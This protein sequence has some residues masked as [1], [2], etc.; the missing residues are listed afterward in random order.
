MSAALRIAVV[1]CGI[2]GLSA[3]L[4]LHRQ[5]HEL[6]LF[7]QFAQPEPVGSGL[8][9]QPTG[10][11]VLAR[12][13]LAHK[14]WARGAEIDGLWGLTRDGKRALDAS[15]ADLGRANCFGIGIHRSS[16]FGI[17]YDAVC[18]E[19]IPMQ[20]GASIASAHPAY[21]RC[22]LY[23]PDN[24]NLGDFDLVV[25]AAGLHSPLVPH[26]FA[27]LP[28][29]A[30]WANVEW[31]DGLGFN[32][33]LLE[34]RYLEARQ[35]VGL[36]PVGRR[37][38]E[39][40]AEAAFFWSITEHDFQSWQKAPLSEWKDQVLALWPQLGPVV[41][42]IHNH[43]QLTYA[44]YAH[45]TLRHPLDRRLIHIGDA[46]HSA[47][48]QLGQGANMALLD[49]W[50]VAR[51]FELASSTDDALRMAVSLRS[52]HVHLYQYVTA[53]FTPLF[54]SQDSLPA[55]IRDRMT[56]PLSKYWPAK[57]I[58]SQLLSGLFGAPL[59]QLGLDVPDYQELANAARIAS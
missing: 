30:L 50:A 20:T 22:R 47:S 18:A 53:F 59:Q 44:R 41:D 55:L 49:A 42:Q 21:D 7:D 45:R 46:W 48:P 2:G 19:G 6:H 13:G 10:M 29:G 54:Q 12:L 5:G 56:A 52:E 39:A 33:R 17:L 8:M 24:S 26:D 36:L 51:G 38:S 15:Y 28:F 25:D 23:G 40:V 27:H 14:A 9:L 11:A 4:L 3:A 43:Q 16:L 37:S 1:G 35:M 58:Q 31:P 34:Q 57:Q 32:Q